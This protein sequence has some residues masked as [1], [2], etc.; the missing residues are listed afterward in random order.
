MKNRN[1]V[2]ALLL[3]VSFFVVAAQSVFAA[4]ALPPSG[5]LNAA[6]G[7]RLMQTLGKKLVI[8]DVR[9]EEEFAQGHIP[10][11]RLLPVQTLGQNLDKVPAE[12]P[13]LIVCRTGRRAEAAYQMIHEAQPQHSALWFLRAV[14]E[15]RADGSF[16]FK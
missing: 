6:E 14:P 2:F 4:E 1:S 12:E 13:V 7:T 8:I 11:A 10:G 9:T 3:V 5:A 15:Y 16:S